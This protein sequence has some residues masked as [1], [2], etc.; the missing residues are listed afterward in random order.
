MLDRELQ[1]REE[2]YKEL[3]ARV[4]YEA[5]ENDHHLTALRHFQKAGQVQNALRVAEIIMPKLDR[6][7]EYSLIIKFLEYFQEA[8]LSPSLA[9]TYGGALIHSEYADRG[10]A[11]LRTLY[12]SNQGG[13]RVFV[14]LCT[15][16]KT[17][18]EATKMLELAEES[19]LYTDDAVDTMRIKISKA[20]ALVALGRYDE[21]L[22][23][24]SEL[25]KVLEASNYRLQL[26]GLLGH[27]CRLYYDVGRYLD[28]EL[29]IRKVLSIYKSFQIDALHLM[30]ELSELLRCQNRLSE[31]SSV[32]DY[33]F[34]LASRQEHDSRAG[35]LALRGDIFMNQM[36]WTKAAENYQKALTLFEREGYKYAIQG[37]RYKLFDAL[38]KSGDYAPAQSILFE[39]LSEEW[40]IEVVGT[41]GL[42]EFYRGLNEFRLENSTS[43]QQKFEMSLSAIVCN[44]ELS[45][46]S[47]IYLLEL[48]RQS[49]TLTKRNIDALIEKLDDLGH[50][51]TLW[52][53]AKSLKPLYEEC[54]ARGW[55][56]ERFAPFTKP[57]PK[58]INE[59]TRSVLNVQTFEDISATL[60]G[61]PIKVP[62]V[63]AAELLVWLALYGP[64][65]REKI[66]DAL[67]DGSNDPRHIEY[68]KLALRRLRTTLAEHVSFNPLIYAERQ[69]RL[70]DELE[71][72]VDARDIL[73]AFEEGDD[74]ARREA[75][76][77]YGSTFLPGVTSEWVE[78]LR[79]ELHDAALTT[80]MGLGAL[81]EHNDLPSALWAYRKAV[82][83]EPLLL[84]GYRALVRLLQASGDQV[85]ARLAYQTYLRVLTTEYGETPDLTFDDLIHKT[86]PEHLN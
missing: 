26:A 41:R 85:G 30:G 56:A 50:D 52:I 6:R 47:R 38:Q 31:A 72:E 1:G 25:T 3:H 67:W 76:E 65:S 12:E 44:P 29:T 10:E 16:A 82:E 66:F 84:D 8:D 33:A 78:A 35:L 58:A 24:I 54:V 51:A 22:T 23:F 53:D 73:R 9:A 32:C 75:L 63:K 13:A 80:A 62:F 59:R 4:G 57:Y 20:S 45:I 43:A 70:A 36:E 68:G 7:A 27:L 19:S 28:C 11:T 49:S 14:H 42:Q 71:I 64:A 34:D 21:A 86:Q 55:S 77:H 15:R 83:I 69:Y 39:A 46:R 74:T 60:D 2:R 48:A 18:G 81:C 79:T 17:K 5:A 37:V 40:V 61:K